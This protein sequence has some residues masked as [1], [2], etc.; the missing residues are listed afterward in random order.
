M[1]MR[2]CNYFAGLNSPSSCLPVS[3]S[4]YFPYLPICLLICPTD[5]FLSISPCFIE[6][7]FAYFAWHI[8][9]LYFPLAPTLCNFCC[10][11]YLFC[12]PDS[13]TSCFCRIPF[14]KPTSTKASALIK[15]QRKGH[16]ISQTLRLRGRRTE[17]EKRFVVRVEKTVVFLTRTLEILGSSVG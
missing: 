6:L 2:S 3:P 5:N 4:G 7:K 15:S 12:T 11:L 17:F 1:L 8:C 9:E 13:C 10:F 14:S 16:N